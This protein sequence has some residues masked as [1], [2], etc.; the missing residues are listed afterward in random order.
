M[1]QKYEVVIVFNPDLEGDALGAEMDKLAAIARDCGGSIDKREI[2]G[3]RQLAYP[4]R[5][6]DYGMYV[7][8]VA[9]GDENFVSTARRQLRLNES[10]LRELI[11]IKDK[12]APDLVI[13]KVERKTSKPSSSFVKPAE[14]DT[15]AKSS[16][17][18]SA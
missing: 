1:I 18:A 11:V 2:W 10:V 13:E 15:A 8:M 12:Y 7:V 16:E 17:A 6:R 5:D 4:I 3:R 9:T 14:G